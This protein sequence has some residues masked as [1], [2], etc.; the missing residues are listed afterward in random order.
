MLYSAPSMNK[1]V[2]K[3]IVGLK[4]CLKIQ[5]FQL[6]TKHKKI[7]QKFNK[8]MHCKLSIVFVISGKLKRINSRTVL[9]RFN[10]FSILSKNP[11]KKLRTLF[12]SYL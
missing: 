2:L 9:Y 7:I 10:S 1:I 4:N 11:P 12:K 3:S 5:G 6:S 8:S